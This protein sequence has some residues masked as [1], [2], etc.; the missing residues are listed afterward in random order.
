VSS[1][2]SSC[3]IP[4]PFDSAQGRLRRGTPDLS[5]RQP[6]HPQP[7]INRAVGGAGR[8]AR[9]LCVLVSFTAR[10]DDSAPTSRNPERSRR[11]KILVLFFPSPKADLCI[12]A[13]RL[14]PSPVGRGFKERDLV[15]RA[16]FARDS[17]FRS[18]SMRK[19]SSV[20]Q[21]ASQMIPS[22]QPKPRAKPKG[23]IP[24]LI[25]PSPC[26]GEDRR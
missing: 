22:H 18:L 6:P 10:L 8:R 23:R 16:F 15:Q 24:T 3:V 12:T 7:R 17:R 2:A 9:D 26:E 21:T 20:I 11:G 13:R 19:T 25:F 1:R 5:R 14:F 4:S